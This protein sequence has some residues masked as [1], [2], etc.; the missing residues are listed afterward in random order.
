MNDKPTDSPLCLDEQ[1]RCYAVN[2]LKALERELE[3]LSSLVHTDTLTGLF[4]YR[5]LM[6]TLDRE[7]ERSARSGRPTALVALDLDYFKQVNDRWG[8]DAGNQVLVEVARRLRQCIRKLDIPCR[9]GG[10]EIFIILPDTNLPQALRV[11]KRVRR[12][13]AEQPFDTDQG[14]IEVTAS[15]G[16]ELYE[17]REA[18]TLADFIRRTDCQLYNA[19]Q[20]GRNRCCHPSLPESDPVSAEEKQALFN[21]FRDSDEH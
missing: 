5:H 21:L 9:Y 1:G 7:M 20:G 6:Q 11:A 8:H 2:R 17:G 12:L 13:I 18:E 4:N 16:L 19:K 10:E 3:T 14:P 15:L